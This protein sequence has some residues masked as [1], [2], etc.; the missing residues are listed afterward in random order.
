MRI[1]DKQPE[2]EAEPE[3]GPLEVETGEALE[4]DRGDIPEMDEAPAEETSELGPQPETH[5][6]PAREDEPSP[7]PIPH[8]VLETARAVMVG[9]V[10]S[11]PDEYV[12]RLE[13]SA[14]EW[15]TITDNSLSSELERELLTSAAAM[16]LL[17]EWMIW[18]RGERT[19]AF[20]DAFGKIGPV[21]VRGRS[22]QWR[23]VSQIRSILRRLW[24]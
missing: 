1:S 3:I 22:G 8:P 9:F 20:T 5:D 13:V 10:E 12:A 6:T 16:C 4:T 18:Y 19:N 7:D 2:S 15:M 14:S 23:I 11:R 24:A 17:Q 21:F